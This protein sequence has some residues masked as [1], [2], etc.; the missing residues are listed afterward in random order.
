V[1][2]HTAPL[3]SST[4][5]AIDSTMTDTSN[6]KSPMEIEDEI[7]RRIA[8]E[9]NDTG[10]SMALP[11]SYEATD[12]AAYEFFLERI[13]IVGLSFD[14]RVLTPGSTQYAL[15]ADPGM[16]ILGHIRIRKVA[17]NISSIS[18]A[19]GTAARS[20]PFDALEMVTGLLLLLMDTFVGWWQTD[21][22][23]AVNTALHTLRPP[24]REHGELYETMH[25]DRRVPSI[26][27]PEKIAQRIVAA[28]PAP[29]RGRGKPPGADNEWARREIELKRDRAEVL[30]GY[31]KRQNVNLDDPRAVA[32]AQERFKK[33]ITRKA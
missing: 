14:R 22:N 17:S 26:S 13:H 16:R 2:E 7:I 6:N 10:Y 5:G 24:D 20:V 21:Y 9:A 29:P 4:G 25:I 3:A 8:R 27:N 31:L 15:L 30:R 32:R 28:L 12:A 23:E 11:V 19:Y 33:A 1:L 18:I